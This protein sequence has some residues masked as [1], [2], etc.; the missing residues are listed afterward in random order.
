MSEEKKEEKKVYEKPEII[1]DI[2]L[3]TRAGSPGPKFPDP[4]ELEILK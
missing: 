3:E 2:T 1:H 4:T